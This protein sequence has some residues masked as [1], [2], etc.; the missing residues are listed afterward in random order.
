VDHVR[1][2]GTGVEDRIVT[3]AAAVEG[4]LAAAMAD[5][6]A[7]LPGRGKPTGSE[8]AGAALEGLGVDLL[9][10]EAFAAAAERWERLGDE[11]AAAA[12]D[13]RAAAALGRCEGATT[14]GTRRRT[15]PVLSPREHEVAR[16]AADGLTNKAIADR[17]VLSVRT[18]ETLLQ[19]SYQKLG[20]E[21]RA[22]L[23]ATLGEPA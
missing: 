2:G 16:L 9:A 3:L 15:R 20:I 8:A 23:A 12:A 18:V 22:D 14:P 5:Y 13:R 17:L 1:V 11:R 21:R 19:R 6:V 10:A 4:P 7:S